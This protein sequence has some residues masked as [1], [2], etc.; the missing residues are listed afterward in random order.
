VAAVRFLKEL[1]LVIGGLLVVAL[2]AFMEWCETW[3]RD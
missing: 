3:R 1:P 2:I